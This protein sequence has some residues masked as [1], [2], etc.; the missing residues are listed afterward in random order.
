[1]PITLHC[2]EL[3]TQA[4]H[5]LSAM[6]KFQPFRGSTHAMLRFYTHGTVR[7]R[8][9]GLATIFAACTRPS[10]ERTRTPVAVSRFSPYTLSVATTTSPRKAATGPN[11]SNQ[12]RLWAW[13]VQCQ[14]ENTASKRGLAKRGSLWVE[15]LRA[16]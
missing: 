7:E 11:S 1:M 9:S 6:T 16:A 5:K 13:S 4:M 10:G 2:L 3:Q 14:Q 15:S 12:A 8:A